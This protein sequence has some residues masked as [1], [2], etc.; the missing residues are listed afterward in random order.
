MSVKNTTNLEK[1]PDNSIDPLAAARAASK[2]KR[3][4]KADAILARQKGKEKAQQEYQK[5]IE[6]RNSF[7]W[8]EEAKLQ[9]KIAIARKAMG[10]RKNEE[11]PP[12][13]HRLIETWR[14]EALLRRFEMDKM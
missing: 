12:E 10:V 4:K 11:N 5:K 14:N 3:Q 8:E 13:I 2:L 1:T 9:K 6:E 7:F